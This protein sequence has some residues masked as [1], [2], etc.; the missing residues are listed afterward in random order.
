MVSLNKMLYPLL[1]TGST[2]KF[3]DRQSSEHDWNIVD[4]N[5]KHQLIR[6]KQW[7]VLY[8]DVYVRSL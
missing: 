4:W 2:Q 1:S 5:L 6:K 3:E 7:V 8:L